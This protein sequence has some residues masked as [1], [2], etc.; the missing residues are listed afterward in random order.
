MKMTVVASYNAVPFM[1][2]VVPSGSTNLTMLS[3]HPALAAHS[4]ATYK[5]DSNTMRMWNNRH[6][7]Q[8][9]I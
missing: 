1:F 7:D 5:S 6:Q 9:T 4:M 3:S 2:T 8:G